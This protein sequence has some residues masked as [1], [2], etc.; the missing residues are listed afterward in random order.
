MAYING[1]KVITLVKAEA[2]AFNVKC[3]TVICSYTTDNTSKGYR[4]FNFYSNDI[5]SNVIDIKI[6]L[7]DANG[8]YVN[9]SEELPS[10]TGWLTTTST[11]QAWYEYTYNTIETAPKSAMAIIF[12]KD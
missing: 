2:A 9:V 1:K 4:H 11:P 12:Y 7:T 10:A 5:T 3:K 6:V 8:N